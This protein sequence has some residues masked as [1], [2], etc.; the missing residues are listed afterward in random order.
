MEVDCADDGEEAIELAKKTEYDIVLL[1]IM[2]PKHDGFEVCQAIREF[3]DMP[4]I[5]LT[6]KGG[7]MDKILAVSYTHLAS[8]W[9]WLV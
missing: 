1:D 2:L 4:I 9:R 6:A 3:S 7:D 5:M 8:F